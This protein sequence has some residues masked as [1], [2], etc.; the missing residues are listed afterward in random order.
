M[1]VSV[2]IVNFNTYELTCACIKSVFDYTKGIDYE[3]ILVDNGS[4]ECTPAVFAKQFP[5][6]KIIASKQNLGFAGG[7]N[8]G[9]KV[10]VGDYI[11]LLNSDTQL[12][13]NSISYT[14]HKCSHLNQFGAATVKIVYPDGR[15]QGAASSFPTISKLLFSQLRLNKIVPDSILHVLGYKYNY[16]KDF[17]PDWIWGAFFFLPRSNINL[18]TDDKLP[19]DFFMYW[20]DTLWCYY[21]KNKFKKRI[22][23]FSQTKVTHHCGSSSSKVGESSLKRNE[24]LYSLLKRNHSKLYV[25]IYRF[26]NF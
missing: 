24:N 19:E 22:Y 9:I 12:T 16:N 21:L 26:L 17:E 3:I 25:A 7:N 8:L 20:E 15:I 10:S 13:E 1:R 23:Y 14:Y 18:F 11:L 4:T 6:I 2:I 5:S